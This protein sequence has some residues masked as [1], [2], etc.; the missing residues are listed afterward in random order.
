MV[1]KIVWSAEAVKNLQ[2]I[3]RY[4]EKDSFFYAE[5]LVRQIYDKATVLLQ[6]PEF[7]K[8]VS[9]QGDITIRRLLHKS[10]RVIYFVREDIVYIIAVFHQARQLPESF[11]IDNLYQ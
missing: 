5:R 2:E 1:Q 10:Y 7:C 3:K 6:H 8:P 4:I 11:D 9:I